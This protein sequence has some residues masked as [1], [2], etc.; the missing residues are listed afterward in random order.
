MNWYNESI[1]FLKN[2]DWVV[3]IFLIV[4]ISLSISFIVRRILTKAVERLEKTSNP[5][6]E[7]VVKAVQKP[8]SLIIW[9]L[10]ITF[11]ADILRVESGAMI[12]DAIDPIRNIGVI[13]IIT[14]FLLQ[15]MKGT[16]EILLSK[17][18]ATGEKDFDKHTVDAISKLISI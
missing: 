15:L 5:W 9:L 8:I 13:V 16:Q 10:G 1:E 11:A 7:L 6:D 4:L 3:Q 18:P 2:H 17:N 14:T 12:F